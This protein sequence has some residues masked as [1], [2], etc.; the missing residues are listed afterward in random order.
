LSEVILYAGD[1]VGL[2]VVKGLPSFDPETGFSDRD[3]VVYLTVQVGEDVF[4]PGKI[5]PTRLIARAYEPGYVAGQPIEFIQTLS[6]VA[7]AA[8]DVA[9]PAEYNVGIAGLA[10]GATYGFVLTAVYPD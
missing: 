8:L 7:E 4:V 10:Y 6:P 3:G 1:R 2:S 9:G 5:A